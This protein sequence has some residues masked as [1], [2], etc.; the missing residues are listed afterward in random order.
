M[1]CYQQFRKKTPLINAQDQYS[2]MSK[3]EK[4]GARHAAVTYLALSH[5]SLSLFW[6]LCVLSSSLLSTVIPSRFGF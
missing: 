3:R 1:C 6:A 5:I 4:C 2:S